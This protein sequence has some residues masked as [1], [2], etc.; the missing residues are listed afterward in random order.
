MREDVNGKLVRGNGYT[1]HLC[2]TCS[3]EF[4][5]RRNAKFCSLQCKNRFNNELNRK[6][7]VI[8]AKY[9]KILEKNYQI[10]TYYIEKGQ[11][12]VKH[13]DLIRSGYQTK[14]HTSQENFKFS[15]G[16]NTMADI[17]FNYALVPLDK[18]TYNLIKHDG[19]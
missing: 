12:K 19:I 16:S 5:G 13:I 1:D 3:E 8:P 7:S 9:F 15:D 11:D 17:C 6:K 10:I 18:E 4:V 14:F 2:K